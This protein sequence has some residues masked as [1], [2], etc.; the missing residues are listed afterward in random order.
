[1]ILTVVHIVAGLSAITAGAIALA[2][3][4]GGTLHRKAGLVFVVTMAVMAALGAAIAA[5]KLHVGFQKFNVM[6]GL[7]TIYL[8]VTALLTVRPGVPRWADKAGAAFAFAL[9]AFSLGLAAVSAGTSKVWW[10]PLVPAIVFGSVALL[11]AMG[12]VRMIRAGGLRGNPRIARHL[13]RMCVAMFIAT[14][15]F[16][17]GQ[18][19]VF[20]DELRGPILM[21]GPM[22]AVLA[23]MIYWLAKMK[24][25]KQGPKG[26]SAPVGLL[27]P[28]A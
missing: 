28:S 8:V 3:A 23:T 14:G 2:A 15:S 1:M 11:A 5:T 24:R 21:F 26:E 7:F 16:F 22:L 10:F 27:R 25:R 9:A 4:K 13:W 6:A 18:A 20:P 19:K 17:A 12:D